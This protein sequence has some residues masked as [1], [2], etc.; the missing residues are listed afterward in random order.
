MLSVRSGDRFMNRE[1]RP[2]RKGIYAL[3]RDGKVHFWY[4]WIERRAGPGQNTA[5]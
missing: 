1:G 4:V 2:R 5:P 3:R